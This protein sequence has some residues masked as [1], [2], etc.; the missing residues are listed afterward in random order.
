LIDLAKEQFDELVEAGIKATDPEE[1]EKIYFELQKRYVDLAV[2][3]PFMEA[4]THRVMR[5]WVQGFIY[6]P[7]YSAQYD[8]YTIQKVQ[9]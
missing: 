7:A 9:K 3:M 1:R 2:G 6:S 5:D 4:T 8:Y